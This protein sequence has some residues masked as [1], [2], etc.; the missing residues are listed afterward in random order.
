MQKQL[1]NKPV[2]IKFVDTVKAYAFPVA[3][4]WMCLISAIIAL[5][6]LSVQGDYKL[7]LT[8][9]VIS[10]FPI[11]IYLTRSLKKRFNA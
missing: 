11:S 2:E 10:T 1:K 5:I 9:I 6:T 7:N 8:S 3:I 4:V